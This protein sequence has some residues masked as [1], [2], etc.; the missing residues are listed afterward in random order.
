MR[1][2]KL[3]FK[4]V[5]QPA[6]A[7]PRKS[8]GSGA[9]DAGDAKKALLQA[10]AALGIKDLREHQKKPLRAVLAGRD[11]F[12]KLATGS[13]KSLIYQLPALS[14]D[15]ITVVIQPLIALMQNQVHALKA[16]GVK[17][18][19]LCSSTPKADAERI[20]R[21]IDSANPA[22]KLLYCTPEGITQPHFVRR[23]HAIAAR[24]KLALFA[25]DEAHC[26]SEWGH[27]FRPS[28]RRLGFLKK[29][30]PSVPCIALTATA[31][32][33]VQSDVLGSLGLSSPEVFVGGFN[34]PEIEYRVRYKDLLND[35][36]A[37]LVAFLKERPG[38]SG[39]IYC[40]K[41]E[42]CNTLAAILRDHG[43][44]ATAYHA[45]LA[46]GE[47]RTAQQRWLANEVRIIVATVAFGMGVDKADVR[48]VVHFTLPKT[49]EGFYQ[50]SGRAGRDGKRSVSLLYYGDQD[51]RTM[52]F[53][54]GKELDRKVAAPS[55]SSSSSVAGGRLAAEDA[56]RKMVEY[57]T[58]PGCRRRKILEYFGEKRGPEAGPSSSSAAAD[59]LCAGGCDHCRDPSACAKTLEK[60]RT[61]LAGAGSFRTTAREAADPKDAM[62]F[63]PEDPPES[64][65]EAEGQGGGR[66]RRR[67]EEDNGPRSASGLPGGGFMRASQL[68]GAPQPRP[69]GRQFFKPGVKVEDAWDA[70]ERAEKAAEARANPSGKKRSALFSLVNRR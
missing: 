50:E 10:C 66:K 56:F 21:D 32:M 9:G 37:D 62:F 4:P 59:A 40:H 36:Y 41:K 20:I 55:S 16:K 5:A 6:P 39:V 27:D 11:V 17:A 24:K 51:R 45:D 2:A 65:D 34:R 61:A 22:T 44:A 63:P 7:A 29:E 57:C 58:G 54:I 53:L 48:F 68:P 18:E 70:L 38:E 14:K 28:Y 26:I 42:D 69:G 35:V 47:R 12:V 30:F 15:G 31:T 43:V 46:D 67:D 23:L 1:Q 19:L 33:K 60:L 8:D 64:E 52:E 49:M 3:E 25:V 13:G